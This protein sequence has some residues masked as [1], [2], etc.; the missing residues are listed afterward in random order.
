ML[1][2]KHKLKKL[3]KKGAIATFAMLAGIGN[4][5]MANNSYPEKTIRWIVPYAPGGASD[6]SARLYSNQMEDLFKRSFV[7]ENKPG[8]S[9]IIG[10]QALLNAKPDGYTVFSVNDSLTTNMLLMDKVPYTLDDF[11]EVSVLVKAP[12]ALISKPDFPAE[13]LSEAIAQIKDKK[14]QFAYGSWGVGSTAHLAMEVLLDKLNAEMTHVPY[15]GAAPSVVALASGQL[16]IMFVDLG[17]ALPFIKS[18]KV[19]LWAMGTKDRNPNFPDT[20]A[21]AEK[22]VPDFDIFAWTGLIS[23]KGT[24]PEA[25]ERLSAAAKEISSRENFSKDQI[26]RGNIAW[27]SS[28]GELK[29]LLEKNYKEAKEIIEKRGIKLN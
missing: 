9:T 6:T 18:G 4:V 14:N 10:T 22:E 29:A 11:A 2:Q 8:G 3:L 24:P 21:L 12:L 27:G 26:E 1:S 7:I 16:D 20:P 19:K 28:P 23:K 25:I 17:T 5:S 13:T 15:N